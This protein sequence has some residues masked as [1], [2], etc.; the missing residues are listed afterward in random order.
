MHDRRAPLPSLIRKM[1]RNLLTLALACAF[2]SPLLSAQGPTPRRAVGP[3]SVV[4]QSMFGGQIFGFDVD[5]NGTEGILTEA[6]FQPDG[7]ILAAV[8]TF[9]Q[10]TGKILRVVKQI[11]SKD[12]FITL[13]VVGAG[14]GL[15]EREHVKGI[16]VD[17]RIYSVL[18]PLSSRRFTGTWTPPLAQ[19]DI[20][21]YVSRLQGTST[22]LFLGFENGGDNHT[23]M[24]ASDVAANTFGSK[25]V[26]PDDPFFFSNAP[27][28]AYDSKKNRAVI[29][30]SE[31]A[32]G[33][34][35]P[36]FEI[37][38]LATGKIT[39]FRGIW[40]AFPFRQGFINGLAMDSA[41]GIACTTTEVD[42]RVEFYNLNKK[43]GFAKELPGAT[44]QL[45]SGTDVAFDPLN[46]L[47]LVAQSVSST[48]P[49]SSI[50]VYDPKGNLIESLDGFNFSNASAVIRTHIALNPTNR[51][52][53]IDGPDVNQLQSFSY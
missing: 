8:E 7:R 35:P 51:T 2:L 52:G 3:G 48:G 21:T 50:H 28:V 38:D 10:A 36:V 33:G 34:P 27:L 24:L 4:V 41:D 15:V 23:F 40:G 42:F 1:I 53:Y 12:D 31:G 44:G 19:D 20:L 30:A 49:G 13:G 29:A 32:V 47:F 39:S 25:F 5:Q 14:V 43:T 9:D 45:Q 17:S 37:I 11:K 26:L 46:K 6:A 16:F 18:N 22:T